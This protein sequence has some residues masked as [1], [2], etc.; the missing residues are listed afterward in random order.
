MAPFRRHP[1]AKYSDQATTKSIC[2][3][4]TQCEQVERDGGCGGRLASCFLLALRVC[5]TH[6]L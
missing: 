1:T 3:A 2:R 5:L 4:L 6:P